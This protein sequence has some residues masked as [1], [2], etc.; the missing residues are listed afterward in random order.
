MEYTVIDSFQFAE[1]ICEQDPTLS[2]GSLDI[3]S[4]FLLTFLLMKLLI[5]ASIGSL[6]TL[7]LSIKGFTKS[8]LKQTL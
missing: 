6:K 1:E 2:M 3:D 8:E 5:S 4:H 7:I